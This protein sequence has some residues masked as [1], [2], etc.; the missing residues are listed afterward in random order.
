MSLYFAERVKEQ[1]ADDRRSD[2]NIVFTK[3]WIINFPIQIQNPDEV[4][5]EEAA[6]ETSFKTSYK[7][8][9]TSWNVWLKNDFTA[10]IIKDARYLKWKGDC[11]ISYTLY[12][13]AEM[14]FEYCKFNIL[15][16][17]GF[18]WTTFV[19][20][21]ECDYTFECLDGTV[22]AQRRILFT[23]SDTMKKQLSPQFHHTVGIVM[24]T[25]AVEKHDFNS[26]LEWISFG[27]EH[28]QSN[29]LEM[30]NSLIANEYYFKLQQTIPITERNMENA[31]YRQ[32]FGRAEAARNMENALYRQFFGRAES[33]RNARYPFPVE[34]ER[35]LADE[36]FEPI[37]LDIILLLL[38]KNMSLYIQDRVKEQE[39]DDIRSD[40]KVVFTKPWIINFPIQIQNP[41]EVNNEEVAA[42]TYFKTSY[43]M[44]STSWNVYLKND[45]TKIFVKNACYEKWKGDFFISYTLYYDAEMRFEFFSST[46]TQMIVK[47][48]EQGVGKMFQTP[49]GYMTRFIEAA[50]NKKF[51]KCVISIEVH[52]PIK[53]FLQPSF[54]RDIFGS[55]NEISDKL[56][57]DYENDFRFEFLKNSD[58]LFECLDGTVPARRRVLFISSDTMRKQ[59]SSPSHYPVG[60]V[61][62][63]V[64]VVK[65]IM[66][67]F[68]SECFKL[69][70]SFNFEYI[71]RLLHA[72]EF[73]EPS[74][75]KEA[76]ITKV[77]EVLCEK[78]VK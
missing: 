51:S 8:A 24:Y 30:I 67:Y 68:H 66:I 32:F 4:N 39:S 7:M 29:L 43:K 2:K 15:I 65:P 26:L 75:Q 62:Y 40:K 48:S 38:S 60:T 41:D 13:D 27:V 53:Y 58:Y 1:K 74:L 14:R 33:T 70:E 36:I 37:D 45:Y 73:F 46:R 28:Y 57:D 20:V 50:N 10:I 61:K 64:A 21:F 54:K 72:I 76:M 63:T 25:V 12:Y 71:D 31:L 49:K 47:R 11:F 78:F 34:F 16:F 23:S 17:I 5:N 69:P 6:A 35:P 52:L 18:L 55:E 22:P 59:L 56:P 9:S 44:S 77:E 3:P 19:N 42:E